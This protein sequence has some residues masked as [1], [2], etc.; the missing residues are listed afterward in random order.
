MSTSHLEMQPAAE[1]PVAAAGTRVVQLVSVVAMAAETAAQVAARRAA[2]KA[3][4]DQAEANAIRADLE[5]RRGAAQAA[6]APLLDPAGYGG[7]TVL[8][9]GRAWAAA[10]AWSPDPEAERATTLAED[11]L[12]EL[13]P[14]V[15]ERYDRLRAQ[16]THPVDAMTRVAPYFDAP[17]V[18][19]ADPV[20]RPAGLAPDQATGGVVLLADADRQTARFPHVTDAPTTAPAATGPAP[21]APPPAPRPVDQQA[22]QALR[23]RAAELPNATVATALSVWDHARTTLPLEAARPFMAQAEQRL[24]QLAPDV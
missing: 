23:S 4:R 5:A 21:D 6:W 10:Q 8:D 19:V 16:G 3:E 22:L 1:E 9:A 24:D 20:T 17:P 15:M 11:R 12:R 7:T 18:R 14:D 2:L 13:R